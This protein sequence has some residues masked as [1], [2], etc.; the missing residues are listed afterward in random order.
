M[1]NEFK[2]KPTEPV[3]EM[4]KYD[5]DSSNQDDNHNGRTIDAYPYICD[6]EAKLTIFGHAFT[7]SELYAISKFI[8][9]LQVKS[10][11]LLTDEQSIPDGSIFIM[12]VVN[13][14][15]DVSFGGFLKK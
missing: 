8:D 10:T 9:R 14:E 4:A 12:K 2:N 5:I 1:T 15:I 11:K 7:I 6:N 3:I 13:H